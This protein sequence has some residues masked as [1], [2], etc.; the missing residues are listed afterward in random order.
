MNDLKW[1]ALAVIAYLFFFRRPSTH[2]A[3]RIDVSLAPNLLVRP[4]PIPP[5]LSHPPIGVNYSP[6]PAPP[7]SSPP[8]PI[9]PNQYRVW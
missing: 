2:L 5:A 6:L 9:Q 1:I 8:G 4:L 7:P 3:G